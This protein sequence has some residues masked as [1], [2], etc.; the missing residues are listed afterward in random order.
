MMKLVIASLLISMASF[1]HAD[2]FK[3]CGI[4]RPPPL[5]IQK[6]YK[7]TEAFVPQSQVRKICK[8]SSAASTVACTNKPMLNN[9]ILACNIYYVPFKRNPK[10]PKCTE[11]RYMY[12]LREHE[13]AHCWHGWQH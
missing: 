13:L 7:Y 11:T 3:D 1:A 10:L 9:K 5:P 6:L 4:E 12:A 8:T 2:A